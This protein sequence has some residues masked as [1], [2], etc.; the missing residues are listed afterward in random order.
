MW[1]CVGSWQCHLLGALR[2]SSVGQLPTP[3]CNDRCRAPF[4][5]LCFKSSNWFPLVFLFFSERWLLNSGLKIHCLA[6]SSPCTAILFRFLSLTL[7]TYLQNCTVRKRVA[8]FEFFSLVILP[9][10][11]VFRPQQ[12]DVVFYSC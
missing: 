12:P 5:A 6:L 10:F 9:P 1:Q 3:Y 8:F 7:L 2:S 11:I 4:D